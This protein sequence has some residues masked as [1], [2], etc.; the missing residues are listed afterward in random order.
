MNSVSRRIF[1]LWSSSILRSNFHSTS[2]LSSQDLLGDNFYTS[3]HRE[4]Q[5]SI[6]KIIDKDINPYIKEWEEKGE[7]PAHE[8]FKKLGDAGL[9]GIHKPKEYGGLGLDYMFNVAM[10]EALGRIKC[11]GIRMAISVQTDMATPALTKQVS[12]LCYTYNKCC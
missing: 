10:L 5:E 9:L 12:K 4:F 11:G 2:Q 3:E 8:L 7:F 6:Y 1:S